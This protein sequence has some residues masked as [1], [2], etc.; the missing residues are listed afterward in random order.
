[1][2]GALYSSLS[3]ILIIYPLRRYHSHY[4]K[5]KNKSQKNYVTFPGDLARIDEAKILTPCS[6]SQNTFAFS[7]SMVNK[8]SAIECQ[9]NDVVKFHVLYVL[10]IAYNT[11]CNDQW[12]QYSY[13]C[14][15]KFE[16][17]HNILTLNV[18]NGW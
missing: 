3:L 1:M 8:L 18:S 17:K 7:F 13:D 11:P 15:S 10:F 5:E 12:A 2:L 16:S 4:T 6:W 9:S 14:F